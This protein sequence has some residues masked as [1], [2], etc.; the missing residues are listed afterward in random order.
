MSKSKKILFQLTGSIACFKA[1]ELISQLVKAG[2]EVKVA[3]SASALKFVGAAT[4]E[5][6]TGN[7]IFNDVFADDQT[8]DHI[9][10]ARW[11]DL[12]LVCPATANTVNK[13]ACGISDDT[14]GTL[15]LANNFQK[16]VWLV[17]AM[18]TQMY[19]HPATQKSFATLQTWGVRVFPTAH[20]TLAC[21]ETG[22]G[23]MLE[24]AQ[25]F[26]AIEDYFTVP[27]ES[28]RKKVLITSG[29]TVEPIDAVRCLSNMSTGRTGALMA[30]TFQQRGWDVTFLSATNSIKPN[31]PVTELISFTHADDLEN[32]LQ[33]AL[34]TQH[35]ATVIHLAAVADFKVSQVSSHKLSSQNPLQLTLT[36]RAKILPRIKS[37][38]ASAQK[39]VVVGF[40]LTSQASAE[41][42]VQKVAAL[43]EHAHVDLV[44]HNDLNEIN[45]AK[46]QH[47][48]TLYQPNKPSQQTQTTQALA[49]A[50]EKRLRELT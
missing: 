19:E 40:K 24:V 23:R 44:V 17:P 15:F 48:A 45:P 35:F 41:E 27:Q 10:L 5:G 21:G 30:E 37:F 26:S 36:P 34:S 3:C 38:A 49:D 1:C 25:L 46:N 43:F 11:A 4:L 9:H 13:L 22:A 8:M 20:G 50:L 47:I 32:K 12:H 29:G 42:R 18:N 14:L 2:Y 31:F 28:V 6:L 33:Q 7:K 16:P 39:P